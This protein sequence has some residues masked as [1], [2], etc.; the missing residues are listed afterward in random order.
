MAFEVRKAEQVIDDLEKRYSCYFVFSYGRRSAS[1]A[2][3]AER[4][5]TEEVVLG[6]L[7]SSVVS[8]LQALRSHLYS[9]EQRSRIVLGKILFPGDIEEFLG[10][11]VYR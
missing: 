2:T 6:P 8:D 3:M 7:K 11:G 1:R 4:V 9:I 5:K 10:L